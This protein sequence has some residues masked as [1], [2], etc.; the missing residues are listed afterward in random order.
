M[1]AGQCARLRP[2]QEAFREKPAQGCGEFGFVVAG[3]GEDAGAVCG[4]GTGS[5]GRDVG[6][7]VISSSPISKV[8]VP[9][10]S[11]RRPSVRYA[12]TTPPVT[13]GAKKTIGRRYFLLSISD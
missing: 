13:S 1:A 4:A 2:E 3:A 8:G 11:L 9:L 6:D 12:T 5:T 7:D 10:G